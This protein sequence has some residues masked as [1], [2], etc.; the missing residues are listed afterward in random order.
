MTPIKGLKVLN[1]SDAHARY[2]RFLKTADAWS[3]VP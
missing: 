3:S 1:V 2:P